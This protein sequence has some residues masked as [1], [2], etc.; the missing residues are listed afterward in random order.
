[1]KYFTQCGADAQERELLIPNSF[2][3]DTGKQNTTI[4][5]ECSKDPCHMGNHAWRSTPVPTGFW[6]RFGDDPDFV[7]EVCGKKGYLP[8]YGAGCG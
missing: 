5:T 2:N 6:A 4:K 7:C 3:G 8:P 1:M